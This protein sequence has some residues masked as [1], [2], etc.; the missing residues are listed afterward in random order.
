MLKFKNTSNNIHDR[1][2]FMIIELKWLNF[3][4]N[5]RLNK[6]CIN[7]NLWRNSKYNDILKIILFYDKK[8]FIFANLVISYQLFKKSIIQIVCFRKQ[9]QRVYIYLL[10]K[11]I[12]H[13][14]K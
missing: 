5:K 6:R 3:E 11:K 10:I 12:Y 8:Y 9:I 14:L 13:K 7:I 4:I 1:W 2:K